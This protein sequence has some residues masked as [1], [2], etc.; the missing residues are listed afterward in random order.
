MDY[1]KSKVNNTNK[2]TSNNTNKKQSIKHFFNKLFK[3]D[4]NVYPISLTNKNNK[5]I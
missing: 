3:N 4:N 1:N 2:Q 5:I